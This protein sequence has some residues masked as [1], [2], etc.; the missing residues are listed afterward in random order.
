MWGESGDADY[1]IGAGE[2][3]EGWDGPPPPIIDPIACWM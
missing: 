2:K 3:K 1:T